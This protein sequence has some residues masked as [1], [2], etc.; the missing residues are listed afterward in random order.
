ML[1]RSTEF[2]HGKRNGL[3]YLILTFVSC[4]S[5]T[6]KSVARANDSCGAKREQCEQGWSVAPSAPLWGEPA[7]SAGTER[8]H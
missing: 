2:L 6:R 4:S 3:V 8:E 7:R 1:S 5:T